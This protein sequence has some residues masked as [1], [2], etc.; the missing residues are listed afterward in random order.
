MN[1]VRL[2]YSTRGSESLMSL[3]GIKVLFYRNSW[4]IGRAS[5]KLLVQDQLAVDPDLLS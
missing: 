4:V 2:I 3:R 1:A 5:S